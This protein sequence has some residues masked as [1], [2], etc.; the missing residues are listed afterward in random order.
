[1]TETALRGRGRGWVQG[2]GLTWQGRT[3]PSPQV[4]GQ[5]QGL[6]ASRCLSVPDPPLAVISWMALCRDPHPP[7]PGSTSAPAVCPQA[8]MGRLRV[9]PGRRPH[10]QPRSGA[11]SPS[12]PCSCPLQLRGGDR[13]FLSPMSHGLGSTVFYFASKLQRKLP[14]E[15]VGW[16]GYTLCTFFWPFICLLRW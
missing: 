16:S 1:M 2:P 15:S 6:P 11:R 12:G 7:S 4:V 8:P 13:G 3:E 14:L 5:G 9:G 10:L